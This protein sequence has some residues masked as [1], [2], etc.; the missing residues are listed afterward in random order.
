MTSVLHEHSKF[1]RFDIRFGRPSLSPA[2]FQAHVRFG[3][4][5]HSLSLSLSPSTLFARHNN[6][7]RK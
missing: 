6:V 2:I 4:E 5:L 1:E 7:Q 3:I